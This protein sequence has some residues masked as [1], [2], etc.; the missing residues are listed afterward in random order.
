VLRQEILDRKVNQETFSE[1]ELWYL[2]YRLLQASYSF[3]KK[4][5]K[6]G[7]IRPANILLDDKGEVTVINVYSFPTEK[8]NYQKSLR[9]NTT[10]YLCT[11]FF[12]AA[13]EELGELEMK[14]NFPKSDPV[15]A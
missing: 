13:P 6:S 15:T 14:I 8:T 11:S 1:S 7:D 5:M 10:T 4:K 3:Q 2:L 9:M 12:Y